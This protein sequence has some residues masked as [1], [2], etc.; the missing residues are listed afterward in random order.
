M[1]LSELLLAIGIIS[2]LFI[3]ARFGFDHYGIYGAI[4]CGLIGPFLGY[5]IAKIPEYIY[6]G[7]TKY[8]IRKKSDEALFQALNP[9]MWQE[10]DYV[11]DELKRRKLDLDSRTSVLYE[12]MKSNEIHKRFKGFFTFKKI[13]PESISCLGDYSPFEPSNICKQKI[14]NL[15]H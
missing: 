1:T 15:S 5:Q 9:E 6:L 11:F 10:I 4:F 7:L 14:E 2:G 13:F 12:L 3:G 8:R